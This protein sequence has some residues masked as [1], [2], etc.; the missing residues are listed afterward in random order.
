MIKKS[1]KMKRMVPKSGRAPDPKKKT[2]MIPR[3]SKKSNY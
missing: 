2:K 3:V 1:K